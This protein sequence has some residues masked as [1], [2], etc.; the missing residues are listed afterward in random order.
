MGEYPVTVKDTDVFLHGTSRKNYQ[1]IQSSG[2]LKHK[3]SHRNWSISTDG[4]CFEKWVKE[5]DEIVMKVVTTYCHS[6]CS[7][8]GSTEGVILKI[9]GKELKKLNCPIYNDPNKNDRLLYDSYGIPIGVDSNSPILSIVVE[10]DIPVE[11]LKEVKRIPYA[12]M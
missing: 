2:F 8:D 11:Y 7:K 12:E 3:V 9:T 5:N 4:V 6:A 1:D 10:S